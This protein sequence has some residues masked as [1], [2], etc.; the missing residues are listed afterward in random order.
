MF[1]RLSVEER[2]SFF[3]TFAEISTLIKND[4]CL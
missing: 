3:L 1:N 2:K 4:F